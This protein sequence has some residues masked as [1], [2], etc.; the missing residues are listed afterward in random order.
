MYVCGTHDDAFDDEGFGSVMMNAGLQHTE[1]LA[2]F[3][4]FVLSFFL[5]LVIPSIHPSLPLPN[6]PPIQHHHSISAQLKQV[7]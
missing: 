5:S 7:G 2:F 4:S 1:R 3:P 6:L